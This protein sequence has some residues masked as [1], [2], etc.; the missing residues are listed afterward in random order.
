M[1]GRHRS[2][3]RLLARLSLT[4]GALALAAASLYLLPTAE[5]APAG[6]ITMNP[7]NASLNAGDTVSLTFDVSGGVDIHRVAI[8]LQYN[9]SVLQVVDAD[10]AAAGT[11]ILPGPFPGTDAE[12]AVTQNN[13]SAGIINYQ[14]ELDGANEV[15]GSGT[16]ATVQFAAVANGNANLSFSLRQFGDGNDVNFTPT[17]S[18]AV[19]VVGGT[20]ALP[21][22]TLTPTPF[23]S[24]TPSAT[25]TSAAASATAT[26]ATSATPTRTPTRTVTAAAATSTATAPAGTPQPTSTARITILQNSNSTPTGGAAGASGPRNGPNPAQAAQAQGLPTAGNDEPPIQWWRWTFFGG[27]LM[28]AFA[29][30]FFTFAVHF[31]DREPILMDRFDAS[32][33]KY[34]KRKK[35]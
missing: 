7:P 8:G 35:Y 13:V 18:A 20:A 26:S 5:A 33:Q 10:A 11:Q 23:P 32:R 12:G 31:G 34:S 24:T 2:R 19:V 30:W 1:Q 9:T 14:F 25:S 17:A 4:A 15:S 6:S 27:A 28:L 22:V 16:I 29:G 3:A 21:T